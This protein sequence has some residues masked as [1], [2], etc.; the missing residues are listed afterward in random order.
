MASDNPTNVEREN[1]MSEPDNIESNPPLDFYI[2]SIEKILEEIK[3]VHGVSITRIDVSWV[4][5]I[6][7]ESSTPD[8]QLSELTWESAKLAGMR[9]PD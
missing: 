4:A 6:A 7:F 3:N 5:L 9:H 2:N 8:Y 1:C